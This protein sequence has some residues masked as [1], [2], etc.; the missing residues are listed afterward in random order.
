MDYGQSM[1]GSKKLKCSSFPE[2]EFRMRDGETITVKEKS[3]TM[4]IAE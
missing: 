2:G 3:R 4:V 1:T